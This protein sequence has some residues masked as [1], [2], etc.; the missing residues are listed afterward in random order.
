M[1][2][3]HN[4]YL[5]EIY[6]FWF[7]NPLV[8]KSIKQK[9]N[10]INLLDLWTN[11][12]FAKGTHQKYIDNIMNKTFISYFDNENLEKYIPKTLEENIAIIIL[13]DQISRNI[14]RRTKN[15]Y[16]YDSK[17]FKFVQNI[18]NNYDIYKLNIEYL[19]V[20]FL[21]C[22]HQEN[23][24]IHNIAKKIL[25]IIKTHS[26]CDKTLYESITN[27]FI[28]HNERIKL[29]GRYPERNNFISRKTND[30]ELIYMKS[31]NYDI[32]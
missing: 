28:N 20:L 30:L 5:L 22:I 26:L 13:Y 31:T 9:I 7:K 21:A 3:I 32:I 12:W 1:N 18:L 6:L 14:F 16:L 2:N 25:N 23:I 24:E 11:V 15:A 27:I 19:L 8:F 17:T 10:S 4:Q 29:F